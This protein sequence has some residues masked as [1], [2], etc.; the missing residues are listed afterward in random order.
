MGILVVLCGLYQGKKSQSIRSATH[1]RLRGNDKHGIPK[2]RKVLSRFE[3]TKPIF[4]SGNG[5]KNRYI[6][7]IRKFPLILGSERQSQSRQNPGYFSAQDSYFAYA[8]R[9]V[10]LE[11]ANSLNMPEMT[12]T[13][14]IYG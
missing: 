4:R 12:R 2:R 1:S 10:S 5:R 8:A 13:G 7:E 6:R 14:V 3:E 11:Y 9:R